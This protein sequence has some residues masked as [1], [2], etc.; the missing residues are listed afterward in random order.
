MA[1]I[2]YVQS[3]TLLKV[4]VLSGILALPLAWFFA[5]NWLSDFS[6]R[7]SLSPL[8]FLLAYSSLIGMLLLLLIAQSWSLATSNPIDS[9]KKD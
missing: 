2:F 9:L 5:T 3:S 7:I 8:I 1:R 6:Y 4:L